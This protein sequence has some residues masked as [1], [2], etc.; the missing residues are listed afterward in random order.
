M[1]ISCYFPTISWLR[2]EQETSWVDIDFEKKDLTSAQ[3]S[4]PSPQDFGETCVSNLVKQNV[5]HFPFIFLTQNFCCAPEKLKFKLLLPDS[6]SV[7]TSHQ[8]WLIRRGL[9]IS[10]HPPCLFLFPSLICSPTKQPYSKVDKFRMYW[11]GNAVFTSNFYQK[12]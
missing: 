4:H 1:I 12:C 3:K 9:L 2:L 11:Y 8:Q 7:S 10:A 5:T 6:V